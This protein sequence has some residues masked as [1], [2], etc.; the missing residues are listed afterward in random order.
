M[1]NEKLFDL[2]EKMYADLKGSQE[3]MYT[4]L[5][6][7]IVSNRQAIVRLENNMMDRTGALFD[8]YKTN[9]EAINRL[10]DKIDTLSS[11]VENNEL[12]IQVIQGGKKSIK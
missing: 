10:E 3:K 12:Q 6:T 9:T 1:E 8:G 4:D 11:K 2:I 5:K 7:E